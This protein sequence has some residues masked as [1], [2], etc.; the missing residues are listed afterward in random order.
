MGSL[1]QTEK[2]LN[3]GH[4]GTELF[5]NW[6]LG[7]APRL[8]DCAPQIRL[9][10]GNVRAWSASNRALLVDMHGSWL[11]LGGVSQRLAIQPS[12][13]LPVQ[14]HLA[15]LLIALVNAYNC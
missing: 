11:D 12:V 2:R 3:S 9:N 15:I 5:L 4:L 14:V 6:S 8:A 10:R 1:N 7:R 13:P